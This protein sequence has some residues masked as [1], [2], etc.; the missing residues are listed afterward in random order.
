MRLCPF[1]TMHEIPSNYMV[2][3]YLSIQKTVTIKVLFELLENYKL[4]EKN[5]DV[6]GKV[7]PLFRW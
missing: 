1:G 7:L 4:F 3:V 6:F 5:L 2:G